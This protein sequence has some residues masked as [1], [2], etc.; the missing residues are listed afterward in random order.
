[1]SEFKATLLGMI[2]TLIIFGAISVTV[3]SIFTNEV[4]EVSTKYTN[5]INSLNA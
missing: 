5:T 4:A 1:M 3:K 2:L